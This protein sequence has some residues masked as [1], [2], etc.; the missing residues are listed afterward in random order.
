MPPGLDDIDWTALGAA[1][2]P[3][4]VRRAGDADADTAMEGFEELIHA[5]Y[6]FG[7]LSPVTAAGLPFLVALT[8]DAHHWRAEMLWC[9]G[10]L[11]DERRRDS[12]HW[13]AA[14][15]AAAAQL[16]R[17]LPHATD[18]DPEVRTAAAYT[19]AQLGD[20]CPRE[21]LRQRWA[22][23]TDPSVLASLVLAL[24]RCEPDPE[25]L[26]RAA[27]RHEA[28]QVRFAAGYALAS[29]GAELDAADLDRLV[30]GY[31]PDS[32]HEL[33][34]GWI[35]GLSTPL[36]ELAPILSADAARA[37]VAG[38]VGHP[39]AAVRSEAL[40]AAGARVDR[41]RSAPAQLLPVVAPA[42][43]DT[44]ERVRRLAF[45]LLRRAGAGAA[46]Y[47]DL[48]AG[49]AG[50]RMPPGGF[51]LTWESVGIDALAALMR[52]GDP[53]WVPAASAALA[54]REGHLLDDEPA[55]TPPVLAAVRAELA[56]L[57]EQA[58][59]RPEA[60]HAIAGLVEILPGWGRAAADAAPEVRAAAPWTPEQAEQALAAMAGDP[61]GGGGPCGFHATGPDDRCDCHTATDVAALLAAA[62]KPCCHP[63]AL[64]RLVALGA[65]AALPRLRDLR[66][67]DDR[68]VTRRDHPIGHVWADERLRAAL[69]EAIEGLES[70]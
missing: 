18:A 31:H 11:A 34:Q 4:Q 55:L 49:A 64:P 5:L 48:L 39:L 40:H 36:A 1:D 47:A 70:R 26:L 69:H 50:L 51:S 24:G 13:P 14:A 29:A 56:R 52:L 7:S 19:L 59:H 44:D 57:T 43:H 65:V 41:S 53:R 42:L 67:R 21:L 38:L 30:D 37:L 68:V 62:E 10:W 46:P 22:A 61:D 33:R 20:A 8:H 58:P 16:P 60:C 2:L 32:V 15:A 66:D 54:Q 6:D 9:V 23:E 25:P 63:R 12:R 17:L 35:D 3:G 27:L 28:H 45:E